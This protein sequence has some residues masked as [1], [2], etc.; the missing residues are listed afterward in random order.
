M[1]RLNLVSSSALMVALCTLLACG[2]SPQQSGEPTPNDPQS[3]Q[4]EGAPAP[5]PSD[6]PAAPAG[7]GDA[8]QGNPG[9]IGKITICHIPPGNP[10]NAHTIT[11]GMPALNAHLKHGDTV[12][13]CGSDGG[14]GGGVDAGPGGEADAGT[15]GE[16]DA[17]TGSG[18]VD[19]GPPVCSP[20]G[21]DCGSSSACCEGLTC[22]PDNTCE[23][24]IG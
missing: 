6:D 12:G 11:V 19:A 2:G 5:S 15:G 21:Q 14:T 1:R 23:I 22:G 4:L 20:E 10:A 24:I 8:S 18:D 9:G 7:N 13:A 16:A 3:G 17:G